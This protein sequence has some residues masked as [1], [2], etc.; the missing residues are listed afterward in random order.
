MQ[1]VVYLAIVVVCLVLAKAGC[2]SMQERLKAA[3]QKKKKGKRKRQSEEDGMG[4]IERGV[5]SGDEDDDS[6]DSPIEMTLVNRKSGTGNKRGG[7]RKNKRWE[8]GSSDS[9]EP[10]EKELKLFE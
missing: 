2:E 1:W 7:G 3:Q 8:K 10:S 6:D 9:S 4:F 5:N